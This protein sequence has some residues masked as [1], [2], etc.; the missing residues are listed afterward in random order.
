VISKY[1]DSLKDKYDEFD[2]REK[3]NKHLDNLMKQLKEKIQ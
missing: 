2:R 1:V 3:K